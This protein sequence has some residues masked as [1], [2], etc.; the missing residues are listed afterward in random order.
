MKQKDYFVRIVNFSIWFKCIFDYILSSRKCKMK[1]YFGIGVSYGITIGKTS[2][3]KSELKKSSKTYDADKEIKTAF[4]AVQTA[5]LE[6]ETLLETENKTARDIISTHLMI[7]KDDTL[8]T[9]I[10]NFI[11]DEHLN[12]E[13]A[14]KKT[15][16]NYIK[17][18]DALEDPYFRE[19]KHDFKDI[20]SRLTDLINAKK[21]PEN[22]KN[23]ILVSDE[24]LLSDI[25]DKNI[26][27]CITSH[28]GTTSHSAILLKSTGKPAVFSVKDIHDIPD[29]Q[30]AIIDSYKGEIIINPDDKT[31]EKYEKLKNSVA[32]HID[33]DEN[34]KTKD[35]ILVKLY[36]NIS[37]AIDL[38][39]AIR[40]KADGIGLYRTEYLYIDKNS[41]PGE[42]EQYLSY[43]DAAEKMHG[44]SVVIRTLDAGGDKN[45][46]Y[47][48]IE[49]EDNPFL[50]L[51]AIRLCLKNKNIFKTQI[52]AVLRAGVHGEIKLM[53]PFITNV[54][55]ILQTKSVIDECAEELKYAGISYKIPKIGIMAETPAVAI[56][57]DKFL[58]YSDFMSIGTNDL[59][60]YTT[61]TDRTNSAVNYNYTV[62]NPAV[63]KLIM[64]LKKHVPDISVC[65]ETAGDLK[66]ERLFLAIGINKFS[67]TPAIIP[68]I[69]KHIKTFDT[70][71][72]KSRLEK[73]LKMDTV[74]EIEEI[75]GK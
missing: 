27:G 14:V 33:T 19:R 5:Q 60:Q 68:E 4:K 65:G 75:F 37:N 16:E 24:I 25:L 44:K 15:F 69:R 23:T 42:E 59:I 56:S 26:I 41:S 64:N 46:P 66:A 55:E 43:K 11:T 21:I 20:M 2:V 10:R 28:I 57:A 52:K 7:L 45:I 54:E 49:D 51:R 72:L 71:E 73:A 6:L 9:D 70:T 13:N 3:L 47:L 12:A 22:Q 50:G 63:I 32:I 1:K 67:V 29:G 48:N 31:L 53:L 8:F 35:G 74:E 39:N 58:K 36:A 40:Y 18:M 61:A 62:F 17:A 34:L 38:E 30:T